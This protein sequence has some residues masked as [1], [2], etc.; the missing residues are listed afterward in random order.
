MPILEITDH[1]D[2]SCPVC[3]VR[4]RSTFHRTRDEVARILDGLIASEGRL[5]VLNLSGGEPTL[6]PHFREIV[7]E[8]LS[9]DELLYVSVSTNGRRLL[10]DPGLL[11]WLAERGVV[12]SLQF[13]GFRESTYERLRG[14]PVAAE[15]CRLL[16]AAETAGACVSLTMTVARGV[17]DDETADVASLLFERDHVASVMLQPLAHVGR[18]AA[19][20]RPPDAVT[21][22]DVVRSLED[23]GKGTVSTED[24]SPL[25]CGHPACFALAFY[26]R[27]DGGAYLPIK[28]MVRADRYLDMIQNRALFGTDAESLDHVREAVNDLWSAP[29]GLVPRSEEVLAAVKRLLGAASC[30]GP[31][32]S[33]RAAHEVHQTVK[34]I[35]IHHFM[36][37]DTFDLARA[38]KC[39]NVYPQVDGRLVPA[40]VHNCLRR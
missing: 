18:G 37:R 5:S 1:C 20:E 26:L 28:Q 16:D 17:N 10:A 32:Q 6:N 31:L 34:S 40:C 11:A 25:P 30:C 29:A 7:E 8:C 22:P 35:F 9:R 39:C 2:L 27:V 4:N 19:L 13:D 14:R 21:I 38:R 3:L 12:I 24:F 36:D 23:A 33:R 15:K